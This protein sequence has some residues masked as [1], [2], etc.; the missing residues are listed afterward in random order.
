MMFQFGGVTPENGLITLASMQP[1]TR[2]GELFQYSNPMASAAGYIAGHV[3]HPEL[4]LGTGYDRAMEEYIFRP[5]GM[6]STTFSYPKALTANHAAPHAPD[7][8][9][10]VSKV[11]MD[12]NYCVIPWRPAGGAWS[13]VKDMISYVAMELS[14]GK[15]PNGKGYIDREPLLERRVPK[16]AMSKDETYGMGLMVDRTYGVPVVHH[17]GDLFGYHSDMIW[18]P[19]HN[20]GAVILTGGDP[21][22]IL[23]TIFRRKLLEVLFDGHAEADEQVA[24]AAKNFYAELAAE[25]KLL[26]DPADPTEVAKLAGRYRNAALGDILLRTEGA[27]TIFDFGEWKS[28]VASKKNPDGTIS[29]VTTAP[30]ASGFEFVVAAGNG[31]KL[32]IRDRQHEYI[33]D[34]E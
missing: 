32:V 23:R 18:L 19:E 27:K 34:G 1:T 13:N 20:V 9:G 10:I 17:G 30:G 15:L 21:G 6:K 3:A 5:L 25:R 33:F 4:D 29:F 22:S 24:A 12:L 11:P 2:F 31:R 26:T 16:V 8:N 28:P 7:I 14:E